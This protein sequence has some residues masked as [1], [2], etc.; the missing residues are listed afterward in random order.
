MID[1][2]FTNFVRKRDGWL[3]FNFFFI[4]A[5]LFMNLIHGNMD[6]LELIMNF[7]PGHTVRFIDIILGWLARVVFIFYHVLFNGLVD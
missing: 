4:G 6:Q 7:K 5:E 2:L 3:G 1:D